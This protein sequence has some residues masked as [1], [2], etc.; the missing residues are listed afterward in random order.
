MTDELR[1]LL[2]NVTDKWLSAWTDPKMV[3]RAYGYLDK[4]EGVTLVDGQGVVA[5]AHGTDDYRTRVFIDDD[6]NL[7]S[8]CSCPVGQRC[9]HAVAVILNVSK[10]IK[11]GGCIAEAAA[12][13]EIWKAAESALAAAR[14]KIEERERKKLEQRQAKEREEEE[15]RK[16]MERRRTEALATFGGFLE[17]TR[18][19][20]ERGDYDGVLKILDE[21][22]NNTDDDFDIEP[23]GGELYGM[24][25]EISRVAAEALGC[26]KMSD[27][28]KILFA[29]DAERPYRYYVSPRAIY[30]EY[31]KEE[32][33]TKF[34]ADV[35]HEA[36]DAL[37]A[38]L[39]DETF[40]EECGY[41]SLCHTVYGACGAYWRAGRG[42]EAFSLRRRFAAK[43]DGWISCADDLCRLGRR[44]DAKTFLLG[45]REFVRSPDSEEWDN[46]SS[47]IEKL[48]EVYAGE[49]K[50]AY[51]AALL[52]ENWLSLVGGRDY[53]GGQYSLE[54][55]LDMAG[56]AGCRRKVFAALAHAVDT[57][58]PP[59]GVTSKE[60]P[61]W[62][63]HEK[64]LPPPFTDRTQPP[65][66]PL[67]PSGIDIGV[68][69]PLFQINA[70]WWEAE[71]VVIRVAIKEGLLD[72][73]ARR[74]KALPPRPG[75]YFGVSREDRLTD[76]E[77]D[78]QKALAG[79]YP[80]VAVRIA[81]TQ[82]FRSWTSNHLGEKVP[83]EIKD[84]LFP[85]INV[86]ENE[87]KR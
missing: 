9:K 39:E 20:Q 76:F 54:R 56:K 6:G 35:W 43:T 28:E 37:K 87:R 36:G 21:A 68:P 33:A 49:G 77:R 85:L 78:V 7:E 23:Y 47:L 46:G 48:A 65:K 53:C 45:A 60:E 25:E 82:E 86:R 15:C 26:C 63:Q 52:A 2:A 62:F 32:N 8:V 34:P 69:N 57:R 74:Y 44:D 30:D 58:V 42:E 72:E 73:A 10:T 41:H 17:R 59:L 24:M 55:I 71:A 64:P 66:W 75:G 3:G 50:F 80:E 4:I 83:K 67:P 5:L 22:C 16:Q 61:V 13:C 14:A 18:N 27:A 12:D 70:H 19:C 11:D 40:V 31:W 51:A 29:H 84:R 1:T 38:R 79:K 81:A